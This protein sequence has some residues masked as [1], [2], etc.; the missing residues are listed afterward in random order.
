MC[1]LDLDLE[2]SRLH[3]KIDRLE[4]LIDSAD[5]TDPDMQR[6]IESWE[7]EIDGLVAEIEDLDSKR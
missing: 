4:A 2:I 6:Q 5:S 1:D 7:N 3:Q